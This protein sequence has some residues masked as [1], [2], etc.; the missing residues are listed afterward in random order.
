MEPFNEYHLDPKQ[1]SFLNLLQEN[2]QTIRDEFILFRQNAS[3]EDRA[4][5]NGHGSEE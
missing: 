2:W 1:F 4:C 5:F 3:S